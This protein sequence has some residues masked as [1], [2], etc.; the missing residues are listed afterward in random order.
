METSNAISLFYSFIS[1][2]ISAYLIFLYYNDRL[3]V[4]EII[5]ISFCCQAYEVSFIGPTITPYFFISTYLLLKFLK[6]FIL[7][8]IRIKYTYLFLFILPLFSSLY[9][10]TYHSVSFN[11]FYNIPISKFFF[12]TKPIFFYI[13]NYLPFFVNSYYI[14]KDK[15]VLNVLYFYNLIVRV[16]L[17][18]CILAFFQILTS[19]STS[20]GLLTEILGVKKRYM[21]ELPSGLSFVRVSA[22]FLEP[23]HFS[24]FLGLSLPIL[25]KNREYFKSA[26]V[27]TT[28]FLTMSQTF[29]IEIVLYIL[30]FVLLKRLLSLRFLVMLTIFIVICLSA[31]IYNS[32]EILI[33]S[34][35]TNK[36]NPIFIILAD[37]FVSRYDGTI[38][39][40]EDSDL[41]GLPF[42]QDLELPVFRFIYDN[43][44]ALITGYG[45]GNSSFLPP[46]YFEGLW[47][48]EAQL[49]GTR[50]NH[51]NLRWF[52]YVSEFGLPI[53]VAL[54]LILTT[55][56][57]GKFEKLYYAFLWSCFFFNEIDMILVA[58]YVILN[59]KKAINS[60]SINFLSR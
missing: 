23:K 49:S 15:K 11:T 8:S 20:N 59:Q 46:R 4:L 52:F 30:I 18:S 10:V 43:P 14:Y 40:A 44:I 22:F 41:G 47:S 57:C 51:M 35:I 2:L 13:K 56:G 33:Q 42:Q 37:R 26:L 16:A 5:V 28:G 38:S 58:F 29:T 19:I 55:V 60:I 12:Y 31:T 53:F 32:R 3:T 54:F 27:I 7:S 9:A 34:A 21:F 25:L 1:I 48:Y 17:I 36:N 39:M 6:D 50:S 45:P 24:A